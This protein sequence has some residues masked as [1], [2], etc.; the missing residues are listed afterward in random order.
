MKPLG[1][2]DLTLIFPHPSQCVRIKVEFVV[3][4]NCTS[5]HFI[6]GNDYLS[7]YGIDISNQKDRYFTIGDNKRQK[8]GFLN[9][10][11]QITVIK[12]E[13]KIPEKDLFISEQLKEAE[14][15]QD[16]TEKMKEKL[17]DLLFKYKNAFATDK[18]P[19]GAII[20][21]EVDIILNLEK[22]YPPLLRR[23]AY[24]ASPRAREALEVHIKELMD[25]G[26]LRKVGHNE[27][28]EVTTPVIITWHN[29]KSRMVGDF[30]AL[31]TY[32]IPEGYPIPRI[33]ET[34]T[35]LSQAKFITAMDSLKG[36]HQNVLTDNA[37]RLLRIIVHCGIFEYLR[38]P[39]VIKNA[40]FHYQR[41]MN[42]I[43]PEE[44]SE[45]WVIIYID[46]IIACSETWE[47]HL[48]RLERVVQKIVQVNMKISLKKCHFAYGELKALG[49]VVS[50]LSLGIDKNEVAAVL[51]KPMPQT[52]KE[53]KS[54]L[55][56]SGYYRQHI[57]D[58]AKIGKSLYKLCDQ[59]TVYEMTEERV[60]AYEELK[61]S[62]SNS[63][64]LL[65]PDW[66]LLFKLYLDAC[67]EGLG[68]ALHQTQIINDKPVEGP[69]C[70]ISRQIKPTEARYEASQME[71]LCLVHMLRWQIAI[72]EY[73]GNITIVHKSGNIHK[74]VDGLSR[75]ALANTPENLAWVPQ[76][77]HHIEGICVTE[78]GTEFFNQVKESYKIDKNCHILSQLLMEDCKDPA[79]SSKLDK[80][81][82]RAFDEG[83][84]HLL[85]GNLHHRTKHKCVMAL[86]EST[87][88]NTS[89]HE[90]HNSVAAGHLSEDRTLERVKS[91]SWWP[92]WKKGVSEYFQTCD[93]FQKA[94]RA[95][96]KR[97]G[98]MIQIHKPKSPWEIAHMDWVTALP[99]GG[100][101][102]YNACLVLVDRYRKTPMFLPFH[103]DDTAMD[104]AIM[105]WNKVISHTCLFQNTISDRDPKFTSA[106]WTN[107]HNLF[108][109][110]LAFSTAYH[111]QTDGLA[112]RMIQTLE[113]MIRIFCVY[114][115]DFKDY[116][117]FT[118]DWC[119]LR[120]PL[121]LE[122]QTS[123][124]SSTG[125]TPAMLKK[126]GIQDF[127]MITSKRT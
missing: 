88:I 52:K 23:P 62:L 124:H 56:F 18:E 17:I 120:P 111:P 126:V 72:Q 27:Q 2:I 41:M 44:L 47:N 77:E 83:R 55:G 80:I 84:F 7:I 108:G 12:N 45:G 103:K 35:R 99:P 22:P 25:L 6:L 26:V 21:H 82:K 32:T 14:F 75:W 5:N 85:D 107:L 90:C 1:I 11:K 42:T 91:Y 110:K 119:T 66:K 74:N 93:R 92:N 125:K 40:P 81:W 20:G 4:D 118:H 46:D 8:F 113:D 63:P 101:R 105:I 76:E 73:R 112:E 65:I 49:H 28:V 54:F 37:K 78:I 58:F 95:T 115:L 16:L 61:N 106:L 50:G 121:E 30:R 100:D 34:L 38:I 48:T 9:N 53:M 89:L 3:M 29:G 123:I 109:T 24:P 31:N 96:G 60:K 39:F 33:P 71:C 104:T 94:N 64:F 51:L 87:L 69:I 127:L 15:N 68:A 59:Q 57:K 70:F 86:T 36:F 10:K 97:F 102:S 79:L 19:L 122:Y 67:G 43:F 117:G 13:E 116:D 114:E 98:M